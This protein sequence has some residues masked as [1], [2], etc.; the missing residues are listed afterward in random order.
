MTSLRFKAHKDYDGNDPK[1]NL[2]LGNEGTSLRQNCRKENL[3][4]VFFLNLFKSDGINRS[5]RDVYYI[6]RTDRDTKNRLLLRVSNEPIENP[7]L[8]MN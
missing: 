3:V 2:F 6:M 5:I 7:S 4:K 1:S 8:E